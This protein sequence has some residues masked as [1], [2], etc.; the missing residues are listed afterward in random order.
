MLM[1]EQF[2]A[3]SAWSL[4]A[5]NPTTGRDATGAG[6]RPGRPLVPAPGQR[7]R[8]RLCPLGPPHAG[9]AWG[10]LVWVASD[11]LELHASLRHWRAMTPGGMRRPRPVRWRAPARGVR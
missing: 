7:R 5:V 4:V 8:L 11:A 9:A 10:G 3:E 2:G 6:G 1:A